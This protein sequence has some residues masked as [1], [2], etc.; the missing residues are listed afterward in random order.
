MKK[1]LIIIITILFLATAAFQV[2]PYARRIRP[3]ASTPVACQENE[4]GYNMT[5]H[6]LVICTNSGF[7]TLA[8][9]GSGGTAA[10]VD[11]AY[12][13]KTANATLSNEFALGS[14]ATG[15]LKNTTATGTPTIATAGDVNS[16]L[17]TQTSNSGKFLTTNGTISSW[18]TVSTGITNG[19]GNNVIPKSDGTNLIASH[20]IEISDRNNIPALNG[21][22]FDSTFFGSD[23]GWSLAATQAV[24]SSYTPNGFLAVLENADS[25]ALNAV[26]GAVAGVYDKRSSGEYGSEGSLNLDTIKTGSANVDGMYGMSMF[27]WNQTGGT[28]GR[29][30][31]ITVSLESDAGH[32]TGDVYGINIKGSFLSGIVDGKSV[33]LF[34]AN[35]SSS[36][37]GG[38][39]AL[40]YNA[41]NENIFA[42]AGDGHVQVG[43]TITS[44]G[45]TGAQTIDKS[46]GSVN[47]AAAAT[48][49]V[50]TSSMVT[51]NSIVLCTIATNDTTLKSVQCVP[52]SGSFTIFTN[53]AATAETRVNFWILNQ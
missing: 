40:Y 11:A 7:V 33:G 35:Q 18:A 37:V 10:P 48:S 8:T 50:V 5:S 14:L 9:G 44:G 2:S 32:I 43:A 3:F 29:M 52:T 4:I 21:G 20:I 22:E 25:G 27:V 16:I 36:A 39:Y 17:P 6:S 45:T 49:L 1:K 28:I 42:V 46:A 30:E 26:S 53:A 12:I 41:T 47:F 31:G 19:A 13:T 24:D 15:I 51:A 38:T 23:S 34:L